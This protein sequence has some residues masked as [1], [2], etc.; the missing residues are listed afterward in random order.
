MSF[1]FTDA[2]VLSDTQMVAK[3]FQNAEVEIINAIR[4][5]NLW[6]DADRVQM[7]KQIKVI[8]TGLEQETVL[9]T[10]PIVEKYYQSGVKDVDEAVGKRGLFQ[11][12]DKT[13]V[14]F[15]VTSLP[16]LKSEYQ[17]EVR[18]MLSNS[19]SNIEKTLN[20]VK[21]ELRAELTSQIATAQITGK[22]KTALSKNLIDKLE[23]NGITGFTIPSENTKNGVINLSTQ[24]Y[25]KGLTQS[26]LI[27]ARASSTIQRAL[28]LGQDLLKISSH[29]NPSKMCQKWQGKI[30]SIT[31]QTSGYT[32]LSDA[33]FNGSYSRGGIFH[34]YCRHTLLVHIPSKVQFNP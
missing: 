25:V 32:K 33:L 19:Y 30:V 14:Q 12:I 5:K 26:T 18:N 16:E 15:I 9:A 28:E 17:S 7:L 34:R 31:G 2:E 10:S 24:A 22:S 20:Q 6:R 4:G 23:S 27:T 11:L 1:T 29:S 8:L 3:I 21:R 13:A